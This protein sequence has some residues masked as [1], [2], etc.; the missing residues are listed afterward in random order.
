MW[1]A[2]GGEGKSLKSL[3]CLR[4][5]GKIPGAGWVLEIGGNCSEQQSGWP[6][7]PYGLV[8]E[9]ILAPARTLR[10]PSAFR[11]P[12]SF[13]TLRAGGL[14]DNRGPKLLQPT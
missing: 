3:M 7:P 11:S 1:V 6:C 5:G 8:R 2:A 12:P 14:L 9:G 4:E 10:C 13:D